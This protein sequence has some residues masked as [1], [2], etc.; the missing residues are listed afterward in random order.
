MIILGNG[1]T[2]DFLK[3]LNALENA[4]VVNLFSKGSHVIWPTV[5]EPGFLS[6]KYCPN[7]WNLGARTTLSA[8]EASSLIEDIITCANVYE[9][10]NRRNTKTTNEDQLYIKA[11]TELSLYLRHLFVLYNSLVNL[12]AGKIKN[13]HWG[14][15]FNRCHKSEVLTEVNIVTYNY[16]IFLERT[17]QE[18][19]I[20]FE[21]DAIGSL[22]DKP[23]AKFRIYK[24]H[25][26]ISFLH[27]AKTEKD[28][29]NIPYNRDI[30]RANPDEFEIGY[31]NLDNNYLINA[32]IPPA[33]DSGR[34]TSNWARNIQEKISEKSKKIDQDDL[35]VICGISYWHVDRS[36]IDEI[37]TQLNSDVCV[38]MINPNPP[39]A[40]SAVLTSLF[41]NYIH[42]V[43]SSVLKRIKID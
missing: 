17:L 37:F 21:I 13:W 1:F 25:G 40:M 23:Q 7:L 38:R 29:F 3:N 43:D 16:D 9:F 15:F 6:Y 5:N 24:P 8:Q 22:Q 32:I 42:H 35:V 41:K 14:D 19:N 12:E 18:L 30:H 34:M 20:P 36:E 33:G 11:Y 39:R 27:K 2:I 28:S 10:S 4:D 31:A 26:S